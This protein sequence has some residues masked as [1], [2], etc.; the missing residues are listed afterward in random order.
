[1]S[2]YIIDIG[3]NDKPVIMVRTKHHI[4]LVF[5]HVTM[6]MFEKDGCLYTRQYPTKEDVDGSSWSEDGETT[7]IESMYLEGQPFDY[8]D[9]YMTPN[10]VVRYAGGHF[11]EINEKH[12]SRLEME[13]LETIKNKLDFLPGYLDS[14][15]TQIEESPDLL[16][17]T[18]NY[19]E[20]D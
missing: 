6:D 19:K 14:G 7:E 20:S 17:Y 2:E 4:S 18:N 10:Q 11:D 3:E 1:M 16:A 5:E 12:A 13:D 15:E 9:K 8:C